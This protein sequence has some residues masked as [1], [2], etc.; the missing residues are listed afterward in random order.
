MKAAALV[1]AGMLSAL[2]LVMV[3]GGRM[4]VAF[5][6]SPHAAQGA[7]PQTLTVDAAAAPEALAAQLAGAGII[8][9]PAWMSLYVEYLY[10]GPAPQA[11][12]YALSASLSPAEIMD[13]L[14]RGAVVTYAVTVA[15]GEDARIIIGHL[16]GAGLASKA[17][18]ETLMRDSAFASRL[19]V[20]S[21]TLEGYLFADTYSFARGLSA[22]A[23]LERMVQAYQRGLPP[24]ILEDARTHG[25]TEAELVTV[26]SLIERARV[27]EGEWPMLSAVFRHRLSDGLPLEHAAALAYGLGKGVDALEPADRAVDSPYNTFARA[28]LPPTAIASPGLAALAA[29]AS[30]VGDARYYAPKPAGEGG[31]YTYCPDEECHRLALERAG[32]PMP[33]RAPTAPK[34]KRAR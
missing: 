7:E 24:R 6:A 1:L 4:L 3:L 31:G 12:E 23:L 32:L 18:L 30:P 15:P 29:A 20:P 11:G 26:A 25:Y 19:G 21:A 9:R 16:A 34:K 17:I 28:G 2:L 13:R 8:G 27:P 33:E 5:V 14:G 22:E 10:R